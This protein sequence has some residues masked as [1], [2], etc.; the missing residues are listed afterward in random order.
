MLGNN[1]YLVGSDGN[2]SSFSIVGTA[3]GACARANTRSPSPSVR[4]VAA[5]HLG[6]GR[7]RLFSSDQSAR[8]SRLRARMLQKR[9]ESSGVNSTRKGGAFFGAVTV[10]A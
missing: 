8:Y 7:V 1:L 10:P 2:L 9:M 4:L 6:S 5:H 3:L